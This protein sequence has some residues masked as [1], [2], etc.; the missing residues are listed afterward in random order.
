[1][2]G[3]ILEGEPGRELRNSRGSVE[4]EREILCTKRKE[5]V[6]HEVGI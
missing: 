4:L 3:S 1:M 2:R 5:K 6:S